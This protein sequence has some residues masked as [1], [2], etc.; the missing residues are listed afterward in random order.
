LK[1]CREDPSAWASHFYHV[2]WVD[3]ATVQKETS[4]SP[5]E[6]THGYPPLLPINALHLM[7]T[8][9]VKPMTTEE[10]ML[11]RVRLM[12]KEEDDE[13]LVLE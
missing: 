13:A 11:A 1:A 10:L 3:C 12:E 4:Y 2:P 8:W 6:A 5:F 7:F 9:D